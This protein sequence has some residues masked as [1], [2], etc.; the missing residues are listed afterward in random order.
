MYVI[1]VQNFESVFT[2]SCQHTN[3][4]F[5][6]FLLSKKG[7]KSCYFRIVLLNVPIMFLASSHS[8]YAFIKVAKTVVRAFPS[9]DVGEVNRGPY[10]TVPRLLVELR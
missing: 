6:F 3:K 7:S 10:V 2:I 1:N 8:A 4:C 5:N 9:N